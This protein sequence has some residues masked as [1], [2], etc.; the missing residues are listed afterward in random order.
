M[1]T[2]KPRYNKL[3]ERLWFDYWYTARGI[4]PPKDFQLRMTSPGDPDIKIY[5]RIS[6]IRR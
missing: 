5:E 3:T 6:I 1:E 4:E 2:I